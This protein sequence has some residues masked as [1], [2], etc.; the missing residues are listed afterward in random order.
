M[1][2]S[3]FLCPR[4]ASLPLFAVGVESAAANAALVSPILLTTAF[5]AVRPVL[6]LSLS[7]SLSSSLIHS[8]EEGMERR[9]KRIEKKRWTGGLQVVNA[10][11]PFHLSSLSH[12]DADWSRDYDHDS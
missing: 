2:L 4:H 12:A 9:E 6:S 3:L 11:L 5:D 1:S 7:L 8:R 10:F